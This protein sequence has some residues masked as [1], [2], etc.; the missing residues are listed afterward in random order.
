MVART[1]A[2]FNWRANRSSYARCLSNP[3]STFRNQSGEIV[4]GAARM[5][6]LKEVL[7]G[8][9]FGIGQSCS[10]RNTGVASIAR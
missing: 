4:D 2:R 10:A 7:V 6:A 9:L 3:E 8:E 1:P 5:Y